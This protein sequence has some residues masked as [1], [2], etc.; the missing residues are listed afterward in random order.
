MSCNVVHVLGRQ[1]VHYTVIIIYRLPVS[2]FLAWQ[3]D[4]VQFLNAEAV[5]LIVLACIYLFFN[6]I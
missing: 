3:R 2:I 4:L 5:A 1:I 6:F